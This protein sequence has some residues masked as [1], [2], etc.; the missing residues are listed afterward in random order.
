MPNQQY[1]EQGLFEI[2]KGVRS[3]KDGVLHQTTTPKVTGKGQVYFVNKFL[4]Q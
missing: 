2:K 3:G 4:N 1:I